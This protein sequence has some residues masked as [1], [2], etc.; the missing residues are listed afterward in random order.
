MLKRE[1]IFPFYIQIVWNA[2][3]QLHNK[4]Y[5]KQLTGKSASNMGYKID[6][7]YFTHCTLSRLRIE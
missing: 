1:I 6:E 3:Y 5:V 7:K 2:F 4:N